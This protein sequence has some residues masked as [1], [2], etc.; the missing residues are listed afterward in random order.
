M[1]FKMSEDRFVK[2]IINNVFNAKFLPST[3][4]Y[5]VTKYYAQDFS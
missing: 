5:E 4:V 1:M 2:N 3:V